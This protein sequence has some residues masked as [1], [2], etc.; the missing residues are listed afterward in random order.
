MGMRINNDIPAMTGARNA[1]KA[2]QALNENLSTLASGLRIKQAADDAA[3]LPIAETFQARVRQFS[4]ES[5]NLQSGISMIQTAEGGLSSQQD[6]VGR[7]RELAVQASSG[8]LADDQREA[9]QAEAR[10][11]IE[12]IGA[13]AA[14]TEFND[15]AL[16]DGAATLT[17]LGVEGGARV[18]IQPSTPAALGIENIDISTA[19]GAVAALNTLD[20]AAGQIGQNRANLG[21][22][23]N[24][25]EHAV[26][27][28]EQGA[29][30]LAEAESRIRDADIARTAIEQA[31]NEMLLRGAFG[32]VAQGGAGPEMAARLLGQ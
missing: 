15:R 7:L 22:Q 24:R 4:Q 9:L 25:L 19:E 32:A 31:R 28:R 16:L 13:T 27:A 11:I 26:E 10:Q 17:D 1:G 21:A 12:Q 3:G 20:H 23:Q 14:E 30:N 29:Q 2:S 18:E 6:G 8:T 5:A